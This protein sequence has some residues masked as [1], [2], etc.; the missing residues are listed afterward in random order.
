M[1]K[2][3]KKTGASPSVHGLTPNKP[4]LRR[5]SNLGHLAKHP[6]YTVNPHMHTPTQTHSHAHHT[7]RP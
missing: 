7:H 4:Y 1:K 6:L 3:E 2:I 5:V